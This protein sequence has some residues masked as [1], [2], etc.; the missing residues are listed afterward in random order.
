MKMGNWEIVRTDT[1][2]RDIKKFRKISG[3]L[4]ELDKKIE[5]LKEEPESLGK[6][7]HGE[8]HPSRSTKYIRSLG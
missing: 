8:L 5:K 7:L 4:L 6:E 2:L 1:F 3:L